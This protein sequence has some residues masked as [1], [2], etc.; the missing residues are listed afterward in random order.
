MDRT[1]FHNEFHAI[2]SKCLRASVLD[3]YMSRPEST[4][5]N[6]QNVERVQ[7]MFLENRRLAVVEI[8]AKKRIS[9]IRN[10]C[11]FKVE[12]PFYATL[13]RHRRLRLNHT[14]SMK[15]SDLEIR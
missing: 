2:G 10:W 9:V 7:V 13:T 3:A 12:Q 15:L 6:E 11:K 8:T 5:R 4:S 14:R 1:V